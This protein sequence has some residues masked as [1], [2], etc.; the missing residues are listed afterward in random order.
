[1]NEFP[2]FKCTSLLHLKAEWTKLYFSSNKFS[3]KETSLVWWIQWM[4]VCH[5]QLTSIN[6]SG[7]LTEEGLL[8]RMIFVRRRH[9]GWLAKIASSLADGTILWLWYKWKISREIWK[10]F[11]THSDQNGKKK[12]KQ[13][14]RWNSVLMDRQQRRCKLSSSS[15]ERAWDDV[16]VL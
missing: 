15:K 13:N 9:F 6:W 4:V 3:K 2:K 5:T 16:T 11:R 14:S 12:P 1:M 7:V 10:G 8:D